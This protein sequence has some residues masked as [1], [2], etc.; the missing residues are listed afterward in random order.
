[1][2]AKHNL[3]NIAYDCDA[4]SGYLHSQSENIVKNV[5]I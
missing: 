4:I 5:K 2:V 3:L 1:M